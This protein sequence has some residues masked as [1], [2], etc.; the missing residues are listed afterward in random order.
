[1]LCL[2]GLHVPDTKIIFKKIKKVVKI[3]N[4]KKVRNVTKIKKRK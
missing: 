4:I 1:M 2:A 3:K